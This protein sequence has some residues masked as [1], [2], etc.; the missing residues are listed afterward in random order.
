MPRMLYTLI[1]ARESKG[2]GAR[3]GVQAFLAVQDLG[4]GWAKKLTFPR[5]RQPASYSA[6]QSPKISNIKKGD[7]SPV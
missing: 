2:G 1:S 3:P 5:A 7:I 6:I 4:G